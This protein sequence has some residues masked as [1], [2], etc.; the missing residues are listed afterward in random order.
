MVS[1]E[2]LQKLKAVFLEDYGY[3]PEDK[4]L[5]LQATHLLTL[6]NIVHRPIKKQWAQDYEQKRKSNKLES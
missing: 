4:E 5:L 1:Q 2:A 3:V 6:M